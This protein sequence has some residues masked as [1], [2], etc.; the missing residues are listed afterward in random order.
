MRATLDFCVDESSG[1]FPTGNLRDTAAQ[2]FARKNEIGSLWFPI[3][4]S[5]KPALRCCG[6]R[7]N[8]KTHAC[9]YIYIYT[10]IYTFMYVYIY[11]DMYIYTCVYIY[12]HVHI[13]VYIFI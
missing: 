9:V 13:H 5:R 10:C 12:I 6:V 3:S 11:I 1:R 7:G 4:F 2:D 8:M